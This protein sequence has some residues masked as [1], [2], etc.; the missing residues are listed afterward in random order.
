MGLSLEA[1]IRNKW[2]PTQCGHPHAETLHIDSTFGAACSG[3]SS[4]PPALLGAF[5]VPGAGW[6]DAR[7]ERRLT[8]SWG[9]S[10]ADLGATVEAAGGFGIGGGIRSW[11]SGG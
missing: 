3:D 8:R 5:S 9:R 6:A 2:V 11:M 10:V 7:R 4:L 1:V